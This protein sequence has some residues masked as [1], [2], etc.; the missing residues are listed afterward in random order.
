LEATDTNERRT[1]GSE[2]VSGHRYNEQ[3]IAEPCSRSLGRL[4]N[5]FLGKVADYGDCE[6]ELKR[7]K[8]QEA[9]TDN[10]RGR[11]KAKTTFRSFIGRSLET[12]REEDF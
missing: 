5:V 3:I 11:R 4:E 2:D 10:T 12:Y 6:E 8:A 1:L 9:H 7:G